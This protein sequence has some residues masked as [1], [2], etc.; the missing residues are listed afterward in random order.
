MVMAELP[1]MSPLQQNMKEIYR[2]G[3]RAR[4]LVHQILTF[5]RRR[6]NDRISIK[7]TP[8][9]KETIKLLRSTTPT[10]IDIQCDIQT[11]KDIVLA[12]PT[13]LH[14]IILNLCTNAVHAM[15]EK[16]GILK[17][18]LSDGNLDPGSARQFRG[19]R[20]GRYVRLTVR[21]TGHGIE[22]RC[23]D[24]IFEPYFTTKEVGK[25]TGMGLAL[26]H[27]IVKGYGGDIDVESELGKGSAFHILLPRVEK[28]VHPVIEQSSPIPRGTERILLVDDEK[29]ALDA[30]QPMLERL[31]Y[32]VTVRTSSIEALEAFRNNPQSFDL[33][34]TDQTMPNMTG[35][36]LA[37]ALIS[38]RSD[39]PVILCTGFS[40]QIDEKKAAD[41]GISAFVMKPIVM[42]EMARKIREVQ[43]KS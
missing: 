8:I 39:I 2:A 33:V 34:I 5:A 25:G 1:S 9:L 28:K 20:P 36:D 12:D 31:G 7:I 14:Q 42:R 24:K 41:I 21:D 23:M 16:G 38:L 32:Q 19:L 22:P 11:E 29:T 4:N 10:T 37:R 35:K 26:V 27:G 15:E 18:I 6:E 43:E 30:V 13:E 17:V 40:E 3:E